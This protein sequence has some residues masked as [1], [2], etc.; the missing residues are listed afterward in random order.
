MNL[1]KNLDTT[2][3]FRFLDGS[4]VKIMT[5]AVD[6]Q[7]DFVAAIRSFF[8][9]NRPFKN[10]KINSEGVFCICKYTQKTHNI[11]KERRLQNHEQIYFPS[12]ISMG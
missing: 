3:L 12:Y 8:H 10:K 11:I 2:T 7:R 1:R 6:G 4:A 9:K 5:L